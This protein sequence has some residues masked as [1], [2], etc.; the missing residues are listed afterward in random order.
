MLENPTISFYDTVIENQLPYR[1]RNSRFYH[2]VDTAL[3]YPQPA[4]CD[5]VVMFH[6]HVWRNSQTTHHRIVC[7]SQL[8][9]TWCGVSFTHSDTVT[10]TIPSVHGA[11]SVVTLEVEVMPTYETYDTLVVCPGYPY[12][13]EGVDYGGPTSFT[14]LLTTPYGCDSIAHVTIMDRSSSFRVGLNY[15]FDS[16]DWHDDPIIF[17]CSPAKLHLRDTTPGG[18]TWRWVLDTPDTAVSS[19]MQT[20]DYEYPYSYDSSA[21]NLMLIVGSDYGC[22]DTVYRLVYIFSSPVAEFEWEPN[23][24]AM[25]DPQVQFYNNTYPLPDTTTYLWEVQN[26]VG[27]EFDTSSA[28]APH[29]RWGQQGDDMTGEYTVNLIAYWLHE[30]EHVSHTCT[31]TATHVVVITNDDLSFPNLVT[32]NGDGINDTWI[33]GNLLEYSN[34]S[35]NELWIYNQ[36]GVLVY[37][38]KD[39]RREEQFWDPNDGNCPN[40]TYYYRFSAMGDYGLVKRNGIIEVLRG[41]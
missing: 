32:P 21:S 10:V 1:Y 36:W 30:V 13:Y 17:G 12:L 39:I 15:S 7:D 23:M 41:E 35:M 5:S 27:G 26:T 33:I 2:A 28:V 9:Y 4:G 6:L 40:G 14:S 18:Y 11:D 20:M 37:H 19:Q 22:F 29:Y 38:V 24:P 3:A 34:Y 8:P 25:H 16:V 31:D